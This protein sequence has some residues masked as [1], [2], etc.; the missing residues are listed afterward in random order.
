MKK[1]IAFQDKSRGFG[2][3]RVSQLFLTVNTNS[4]DLISEQQLKQVANSYF[5]N[6]EEFIRFLHKDHNRNNVEHIDDIKIQ[7]SV[8]IGKK[9]KRVHLH[10]LIRIEHRTKLQLDL[11]KTTT[12]FKKQLDLKNLYLHVD[13]IPDNTTSLIKYMRKPN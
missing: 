11:R 4:Q 13:F 7:S 12:F 1:K 8:E 6:M 9:E 2:K 10:A 3:D 5:E